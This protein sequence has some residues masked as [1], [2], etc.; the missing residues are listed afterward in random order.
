MFN[1]KPNCKSKMKKLIAFII[2]CAYILG[3]I[4]GFGYAAWG[5][6]WPIAVAVIILAVM[7]WPTFKEAVKQLK[8]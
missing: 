8:E 5:G 7:A 3:T 4:G 2:F 6:S 1:V